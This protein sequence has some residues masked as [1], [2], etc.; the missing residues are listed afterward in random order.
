MNEHA[1]FPGTGEPTK[2]E[3]EAS[4]TRM[5]VCGADE[6]NENKGL[7]VLPVPG[8]M[9]LRAIRLGRV[10][11]PLYQELTFP[12]MSRENQLCDADWPLVMLDHDENGQA[13]LRRSYHSNFGVWQPGERVFVTGVWEGEEVQQQQAAPGRRRFP[14][15]GGSSLAAGR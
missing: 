13:V 8:L 5:F 10:E 4:S 14:H 12:H 15:V 6:K 3:M 9:E 2:A 1:L 11:I 7:T